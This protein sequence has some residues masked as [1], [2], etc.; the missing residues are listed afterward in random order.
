[1]GCQQWHVGSKTLI[2]QNFPV[3][4]NRGCITVA[5][6]MCAE[7]VKKGTQGGK[8]QT[9]TSPTIPRRYVTVSSDVVQPWHWRP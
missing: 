1:M 6:W 5:R 2:Q 4:L 8:W 7:Q 9:E 3:L